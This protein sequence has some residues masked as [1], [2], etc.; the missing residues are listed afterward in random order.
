M[1]E[2]ND[3]NAGLIGQPIPTGDDTLPR[4]IFCRCGH[5]RDD[6]GSRIEQRD[7]EKVYVQQCEHC[8]CTV[9]TDKDGPLS[10]MIDSF[11]KR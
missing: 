9:F 4:L 10:R 6:H 11:Q 3:H 5:E 7:G 1:D 8:P 2:K